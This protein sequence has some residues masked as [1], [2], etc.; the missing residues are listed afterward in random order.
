M[1]FGASGLGLRLLEL[2]VLGFLGASGLDF[3]FFW[4]WGL[5]LGPLFGAWGLGLRLLELGV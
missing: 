4:A 1:V 3:S 5:G 2:R